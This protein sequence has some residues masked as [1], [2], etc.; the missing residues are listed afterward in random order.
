VV[1]LTTGE[2]VLLVG[3][4]A[5]RDMRYMNERFEAGELTTCDRRP[6]QLDDA[7]EAF[8]RFGAGDHKARS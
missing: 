6:Y 2:I 3:L 8:R 5:N 7:R 1:R 4:K